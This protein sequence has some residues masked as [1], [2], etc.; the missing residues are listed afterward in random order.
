MIML[1]YIILLIALPALAHAQLWLEDQLAGAKAEVVVSQ[2]VAL[3]ADL[4]LGPDICLRV[5]P[6]GRIDQREHTLHVACLDAGPYQIFDPVAKGVIRLGSAVIRLPQWWGARTDDRRDDTEAFRCWAEVMTSN[7]TARVPA[8]VYFLN[9]GVGITASNITITAYGAVFVQRAHKAVCF[10]LN[11]KASPEEKGTVQNSVRWFGGRLQGGSGQPLDNEN[12]GFRVRA[13]TRGEIAGVLGTGFGRAFIE[14]N[15]RD[16][17]FL[18]D[19][20][21]YNNNVHVLV[22]DYQHNGNPQIFGLEDCVF[23]THYKAGVLLRGAANDFRVVRSSFV[24]SDAI[25]IRT[26]LPTF[27][28]QAVVVKDCSFEGGR[29]GGFYVRT[30][31]EPG[32][33]L[34]NLIIRDNTFQINTSKCLDISNV[35]GCTIDGNQFLS[36]QE[37]MIEIDVNSCQIVLGRNTYLGLEKV[38]QAVRFYCAREEITLSPNFFPVVNAKQTRLV[39]DKSDIGVI[40]LLPGEGGG[41][42][43]QAARILPPKA[44]WLDIKVEVRSE[45]GDAPALLTLSSGEGR[46][47]AWKATLAPEETQYQALV[48]VSGSKANFRLINPA[49]SKVKVGVMVK[50]LIY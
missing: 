46:A 1:R 37:G 25:L 49:Q 2:P 12:V 32:R 38:S 9:G 45:A 16:G 48:P 44:A 3:R 47:P 8:G 39:F 7:T 23:T 29:L 5:L 15:P 13:I 20:H 50:A 11:A 6:G 10:D 28:G 4:D 42:A 30:S 26:G 22:E 43:A 24:G 40:Q 21:G 35:I 27:P 18:R 14:I 33:P 17:F 31:P 34:R 36:S 19:C 41:L